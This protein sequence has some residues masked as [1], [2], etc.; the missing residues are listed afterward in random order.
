MN[1]TRTSTGELTA[2]ITVEV[3][4]VDYLDQYNQQIKKLAKEV[5]M[6]GFRPGKVPTGLIEKKYGLAVKAE[7]INK[8]VSEEITR[9]IEAEHLQLLGDPLPNPNP[10]GTNFDTG[11]NFSFSFDICLIPDFDP[12]LTDLDIDRYVISGIDEAMLERL[13]ERYRYKYAQ[14]TDQDEITSESIIEFRLKELDENGNIKTGGLIRSRSVS[15][16]SIADKSLIEQLIG[17]KPGDQ[18]I[19]DPAKIYGSEESAANQ[20]YIGVEN[21]QKAHGFSMEIDRVYQLQLPELNADFFQKVFPDQQIETLEDFKKAITEV[22][23][24]ATQDMADDLLIRDLIAALRK[25]HPFDLPENFLIRWLFTLNEGKYT[26]EQIRRELPEIKSNLIDE[27]IESK[28]KAKYSDLNITSEMLKEDLKSATKSY[29]KQHSADY[30]E[31]DLE[32]FAERFASEWMGNK[33]NAEDLRKRK[34]SMYRAR[35]L[36]LIKNQVPLKVHEVT[37][38]EFF[39]KM[40]QQHPHD[41]VESDVHHHDEDH[42]HDHD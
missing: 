29:F 10:D 40:D 41:Q 20:L 33:Q 5:T 3:A 31:E 6:P 23:I 16:N 32:R 36:E 37:A 4:E 7:V 30:S 2:T 21:L 15:I 38:E 28:L 8:L 22:H 35:L 24:K 34:A 13:V 1:I 42:H 9:Y 39:R 18:I 27:I 12:V 25:K 26:E 17:Q 14:E 11:K 19:T